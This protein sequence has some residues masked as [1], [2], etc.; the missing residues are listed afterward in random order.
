MSTIVIDTIEIGERHRTD[1]GDLDSLARSIEEIGLLHP[2]V[3]T[4][5]LKLIAGHRRIAAYRK[6]GREEIP[7][8]VI[9]LD[10]VIRGEWAENAERKAFTPSESVAIGRIIEER[11][12]ASA[13][14]R[15]TRHRSSD[16]LS[17]QA[18]GDTRDRVGKALGIAGA[19]YSQAKA[20]VA[21]AEAD[22]E[23]FGAIKAEMDR[24]GKVNPAY[25]KVREGGGV[26]Q[27]NSRVAIATRREHIIRLG[28]ERHS[29]DAIAAKVGV[30]PETVSKVLRDAGVETVAQRVGSLQKP[31][32]NQT[33]EGIIS[34]AV[35]AENAVALVLADWESLDRT[36][37]QRWSEELRTA[38]RTFSRLERRLHKW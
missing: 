4:P 3:I 35:P 20:V 24:T 6:L 9:D 33:M 28:Q 12:Q 27:R 8:T 26:S 5:E 22:P 21:A 2:V 34:Q 25:K 37:F 31:K 1:M 14:A 10:E 11:E 38:I 13:K 16:K 17:E 18:K 15:M 32:T 30:H 23:M 19:T 7:A 29:V 36:Q